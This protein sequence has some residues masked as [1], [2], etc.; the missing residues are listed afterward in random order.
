MADKILLPDEESLDPDTWEVYRKTGHQMV[1]DMLSF[2]KDI[3]RQPV[4][5]KPPETVKAFLNQDLPTGERPL[6]E[7]YQDFLTHILPF[8][9]G[10]IHPGYFSWVEGTGTFSGALSD[11]LAS[12]MNSNL[13]IGD[14]SAVY[15]EQQTLNWCKQIVGYPASSSGVFT[16]GG[17]IAN[18]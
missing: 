7:V 18:L 2:L 12:S 16:S 4:W 15:V 9:K 8:R 13:G 17:S 3:R 6:A 1:D 10:N 14:H 11:F 5:T